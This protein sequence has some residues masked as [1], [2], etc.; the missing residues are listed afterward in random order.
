MGI[1]PLQV[2]PTL[3]GGVLVVHTLGAEMIGASVHALAWKLMKD[4]RDQ[5]QAAAGQ[6]GRPGWSLQE[7]SSSHIP[8]R[9]H[10]P[11][12]TMHPRPRW[13]ASAHEVGW[14]LSAGACAPR[15]GHTLDPDVPGEGAEGPPWAV[16]PATAVA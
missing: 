9:G 14:H 8:V 16:V 3:A 6:R 2:A 7:L 4:D 15:R 5:L 10:T 11:V 12:P 13:P 1:P